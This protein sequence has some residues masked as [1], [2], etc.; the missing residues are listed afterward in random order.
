MKRQVL[1]VSIVLFAIAWWLV[2]R[3]A[4][5]QWYENSSF[6]YQ[7]LTAALVILWC[8]IPVG[9]VVRLVSAFFSQ[10]VR[11]SIMSHKLV[12]V[13]WFIL[14]GAIA[15]CLLAPIMFVGKTKG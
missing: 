8:S 7:V 10:R 11:D 6:A 14:A 12:H 9:A 2:W 3:Y 13:M 1:S 15:F 5:S 4:T